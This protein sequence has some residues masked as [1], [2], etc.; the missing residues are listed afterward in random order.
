[1]TYLIKRGK[2]ALRFRA[3]AH[4]AAYDQFGNIVGAWCPVVVD[5]RWMSS[6]V[7]WGLKRCKHCLKQIARASL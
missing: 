1:M 2:S 7:P 3:H 4:I 6:N 5:G